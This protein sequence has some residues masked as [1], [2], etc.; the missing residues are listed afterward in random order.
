MAGDIAGYSRLMG[1]DEAG[2]ARQLRD[3]LAAV[4]AVI[5]RHHGRVVKTMGDGLLIE[6]P[7]AVAAVEG[8]I[9]LQRRM[10]RRNARQPADRRM[11]FRI[12]VNLGDVLVQGDELVDAEKGGHIWAERYDRRMDD[13]F[14]VQDEITGNIVASI[15][16]HLYAR[17]GYRAASKPPPK[18]S[19]YGAWSSARSLSST[20]SAAA[21]TRRRNAC[22]TA[23]SRSIRAMR[24]LMRF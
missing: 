19:T 16:P 20:S 3:H 13:I 21:T 6:F 11:L 1:R 7:S 15:E 9:T 12:S 22:C 2:T 14:A 23:R 5:E 10:E 18:M 24:A 17:E 4:H 8:A